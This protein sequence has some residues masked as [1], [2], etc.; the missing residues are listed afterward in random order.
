MIISHKYKFI[1]IANGKT[2]TTSVEKEIGHLHDEPDLVVQARHL[3][4]EKHVPAPVLREILGANIWNTYYKFG[5]VRHPFDRFLSIWGHYLN[6]VPIEVGRLLR[7]PRSYIKFR[8]SIRGLD[9]PPMISPVTRV[10]AEKVLRLT[11]EAR[12]RF[13]LAT[14]MQYPMFYDSHGDLCVDHIG[15]YEHLAEELSHISRRIGINFPKLQRLNES[16]YRRTVDFDDAATS[17]LSEV[18]EKD[19]SLFQYEQ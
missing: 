1:F 12:I 4:N 14:N 17:L 6:Q 18:Y 13:V 3:F 11:E 7:H 10:D 16:K 9:I 19:L 2:G 8:K 5:F 15:K